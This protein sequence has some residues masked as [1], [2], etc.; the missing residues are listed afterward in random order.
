MKNAFD[1]Y[2]QLNKKEKITY[3]DLIKLS[4]F[5][6]VNPINPQV[7]V[8]NAM[9]NYIHLLLDKNN[10]YLMFC[11]NFE[12]YENVVKIIDIATQYNFI[13]GYELPVALMLQDYPNS[14]L[15]QS[16][17]EDLLCFT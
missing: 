16:V 9:T 12:H 2:K 7:R 5:D 11:L 14:K 3:D 1:F 8:Q 13:E 10:F 4:K 6:Y 15:L 17:R